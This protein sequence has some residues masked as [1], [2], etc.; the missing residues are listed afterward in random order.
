MSAPSTH[1][2]AVRLIANYLPQF[3][4][5]PENDR[6][7]GPGFTEWTNV[8]K[9]RPLFPGHYQ[10]HVPADLGFYDLRVSEVRERQA[11]L[12]RAAG[13]EA[14]CYWH[15]WFGNGRMILERPLQEVA[16]T[17][18]PDF[19][20][21]VGWANESWT[22]IWHGAANRMLIEQQ[23]PGER[24]WIAHFEYLLP[25]FFDPRYVR[26]DGKPLFLLFKP[27]QLP[28]CARFVE[29]WRELATKHG[30]PGLHLVAYEQDTWSPGAHGFDAAT[31]AHQS[32]MKWVYRDAHA[33][34]AER[35]A[36]GLPVHVYDYAEAVPW[37]HGERYPDF[38]LGDDH[39]PSIVCGWDNSPRSGIAATILDGYHPELFRRHARQ[40]MRRVLHKPPDRRIVF[41]KSWNEWAEGNYLEPEIRYGRAYLEVLREE[42]DAL[43]DPF[44]PPPAERTWEAKHGPAAVLREDDPQPATP[45]DHLVATLVARVREAGHLPEALLL[46]RGADRLD[47]A[48]LSLVVAAGELVRR[49]SPGELRLL[50]AGG[51]LND[52]S[53]RDAV[54]SCCATVVAVGSA[55]R[56]MVHDARASYVSPDLLE[57]EMPATTFDLVTSLGAHETSTPMFAVAALARRVANGG[58]LFAALAFDPAPPASGPAC[59]AR[60]L[61]ELAGSLEGQGFDVTRSIYKRV[62]GVGWVITAPLDPAVERDAGGRAIAVAFV[63][64]RRR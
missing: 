41:A 9:A 28:D 20:F 19:P 23:Y 6:F 52:A 62:P 38:A 1:R 58:T 64:A 32:I 34:A 43:G 36:R 59:D 17:G 30:L 26:V 25:M 12:A 3:H 18:R 37:M 54:S 40:V 5:T 24:D 55:G 39:Y 63:S 29:C 15:Y 61:D 45:A 31:W 49:S 47:V 51:G 56:R 48:G 44:A 13:I 60:S 46:T 35:S 14:F 7:W 50:D 22:G 53:V 16:A 27:A 2:E 42:V 33:R 4:P 8:A 57:A 11:E 10:P 21:C